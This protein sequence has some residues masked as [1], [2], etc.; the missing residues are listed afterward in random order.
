[1]DA[2]LIVGRLMEMQISVHH[3]MKVKRTR[4]CT[5]KNILWAFGGGVFQKV[6]NKLFLINGND[7][8]KL[9]FSL[10]WR[11]IINYFW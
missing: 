2:I 5:N 6:L 9:R 11:A 1:V 4:M 8:N 3:K 7:G 10:H